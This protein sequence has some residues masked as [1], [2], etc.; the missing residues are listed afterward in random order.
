[1]NFDLLDIV[2]NKPE[3]KQN[4]I[5]IY[6]SFI[7]ITNILHFFYK[8]YYI[9]SL[10]FFILYITS[11]IYHSDNNFLSNIL[12]K[13]AICGVVSYGLYMLNDKADF[14]TS[15][16]SILISFTIGFTFLSVIYLFIYGR[17]INN[18]CFNPDTCISNYFHCLIHL[19]SSFGHHLII[20]L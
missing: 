9:Y 6:S 14:N 11:I 10:L 3:I 17:Y 8:K 4:N 19:I 15:T 13:V 1:M 7:F 20:L 5:L 12:D 2:S 16:Q 18:Y